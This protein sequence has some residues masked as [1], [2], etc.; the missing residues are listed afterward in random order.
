[1]LNEN[2]GC[3]VSNLRIS[4]QWPQNIKPSRAVLGA[5]PCVIARVAHVRLA[6]LATPMECLVEREGSRPGSGFQ[7]SR[8]RCLA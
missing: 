4:R 3:L 2:A 7:P 1:M 5:G 8:S 6:L